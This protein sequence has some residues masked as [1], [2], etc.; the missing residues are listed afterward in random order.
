MAFAVLLALVMSM[1]PV[2]ASADTLI[3]VPVV[4][5]TVSEPRTTYSGLQYQTYV[6][7]GDPSNGYVLILGH[8]NAEITSLQI[9]DTIEGY[10]VQEIQEYA[11]YGY[12]N[13]TS[14]KLSK[15][16][17]TIGEAAFHYCTALTSVTLPEGMKK[18]RN[19]VFGGCHSL[20]QVTLP[21]TLES[22]GYEAFH[23]CYALR[24]ISL[25]QSLTEIGGRA[26]ADCRA[27]TELNIP[28]SVKSVGNNVVSGCDSLTALTVAPGNAHVRMENGL[29]IAGTSV[30][31][32]D[33]S[34]SGACV[35]PQGVTAIADEV[36]FGCTGLTEITLPEGLETIG[37]AAFSGCTSLKAIN[38]PTTLTA[39]E[40]QAFSDCTALEA[41][42]LPEGLETLSYAAFKN[43]SSLTDISLPAS[44]TKIDGA[45]FYGC[46]ALQEI[47]LPEGLTSL[48][49]AVFQGCVSLETVNIPNQI[50]A[51]SESLFQDCAALKAVEL[52]DSVT[53]I[54]LNSFAGCTSLDE[55]TFPAA[56]TFLGGYAFEGCT[57]LTELHIPT[58]LGTIGSGAFAGCTGLMELH[59]PTTLETIGSGAFA[60]C[61]GV[62]QLTVEA[63]HPTYTAENGILYQDNGATIHT[64]LASKTGKFTVGADVTRI[65]SSAFSG[66]S[67]LTEIVLPDT[68]TEIESNVFENCTALSV[69]NLPDGLTQLGYGAFLNCDS[70]TTVEIPAGVT[71]VPS[72]CFASCDKLTAFTVAP[73]NTVYEARNGILYDLATGT[74]VM[75]PSGVS[76]RF[77]TPSGVT[78]LADSALSG[79]NRLTDVILSDDVVTVGLGA[80]S[81]CDALASID[82]SASSAEIPWFALNG[83]ENLQKIIIPSSVTSISYNATAGC[84]SLQDIYY[85]GTAEQ[86]AEVTVDSSN[87]AVLNATVHF[88]CSADNENHSYVRSFFDPTCTEDGY[89]VDTCTICGYTITVDYVSELV[90]KAKSAASPALHAPG[91]KYNAEF[92]ANQ[93]ISMYRKNDT[94]GADFLTVPADEFEAELHARFVVS[95]EQLNQIRNYAEIAEKYHATYLVY[96]AEARTYTIDNRGGM[97]GW[98]LGREYMGLVDHGETFDVYYGDVDAQYL[99]Q[100]LPEGVN[101]YEYWNAHFDPVTQTLEYQGHIYEMDPEGT[102]YTILS[103]GLTGKFATVEWYGDRIRIISVTEYGEG[104]LPDR[105]DDPDG[106]ALGHEFGPWT[107]SRQATCAEQGQLVR[108]CSRCQ[109]QETQYFDPLKHVYMNG[110]CVHC[111]EEGE[112]QLTGKPFDD[113]SESDYFYQPI[114][115]AAGNNIAAGTGGGKFFPSLACTRAQVVTFLWRAMGKPQPEEVAT[116]FSDVSESNVYLDAISWAVENGITS[117]TSATT[118]SPNATCT[119][120]QM[121]TFL[122]R[123]MGKPQPTSTYNPFTDVSESDYFYIPVLWAIENGITAGTSAT[124][125]SPNAPCTRGQV[126]TFL[127]RAFSD[128]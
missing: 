1:M 77:Y 127:Y 108:T 96:D 33:P 4:S 10:P 42:Y 95:T 106:K 30:V 40:A 102:P 47:R 31:W 97:G 35:V 126:V 36:F 13:L 89:C 56:L 49:S 27:L 98:Y 17:K 24:E 103:V 90:Y 72:G 71:S 3:A 34:I 39:L 68:M 64:V 107:V 125:F 22:I 109:T 124:T 94:T 87:T 83:C 46:T 117:G 111:G 44:L 61:T 120:V 12:E 65:M 119:R 59:I 101:A 58:T 43:C 70:L 104:E 7:T 41:I 128:Q 81:G 45:A 6:V 78:A 112:S 74:L 62:T 51:I 11:F 37:Y 63:G 80:F 92:M 32:V 48:G 118:F 15:N 85:E 115:W 93:V 67:D 66:C 79:C 28:A 5:Y 105:F 14:L 114:L 69:L 20:A 9:P 113:V 123:V 57:G 84:N 16:T 86:W 38:L 91:T 110:N 25:P 29:L 99:S 23:N 19:D 73:G 55:V 88:W 52:P 2:T 50:K 75:V 116:G 26:F 21:S 60:G 82:W 76:G 53:S 8:E 121:V 18:L 122:W 100:V 54:D